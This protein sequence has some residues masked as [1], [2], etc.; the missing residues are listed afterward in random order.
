M[1]VNIVNSGAKLRFFDV[2]WED[3]WVDDVGMGGWRIFDVRWGDG[4]MDER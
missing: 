2:G 4:E 1:F 3:V